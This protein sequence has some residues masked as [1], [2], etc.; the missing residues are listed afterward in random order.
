MSNDDESTVTAPHMQMKVK[1]EKG[2]TKPDTAA[3]VRKVKLEPVAS[4]EEVGAS[5]KAKET[6]RVKQEPKDISSNKKPRVSP[7]RAQAVADEMKKELVD[8]Y[9]MGITT[10]QLDVLAPAVGYTHPRSDAILAAVKL[11]HKDDI[12]NKTSKDKKQY[13]ELTDKGIKELV[14]KEEA[15]VD[16]EK[17]MEKLWSTAEKKLSTSSK[18]SSSKARDSALAM[19]N[20]LKTGEGYTK[21]QL[22][23]VT[24][25]GMERSTGFPETLKVYADLGMTEKDGALIRFTQKMFPFGRP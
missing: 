24:H 15:P 18:T 19:W 20:L 21:N 5:H 12:A 9:V 8:N 10:M 23:D 16:N 6:K 2:A 25:Y 7:E 4:Q 11:L 14:P 3:S 17:A 22:L 13:M 1:E